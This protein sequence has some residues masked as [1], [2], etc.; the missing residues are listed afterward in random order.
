MAKSL[1]SSAKIAS[2]QRKSIT[3]KINS[4][5]ASKQL[6][7][8]WVASIRKAYSN[9]KQAQNEY[10]TKKGKWTTDKYVKS[11]KTYNNTY[12][13]HAWAIDRYS[14]KWKEYSSYDFPRW[15]AGTYQKAKLEAYWY[16][17]K[18][19]QKNQNRWAWVTWKRVPT[20]KKK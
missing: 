4:S 20:S 9:Y 17:Q 15:A 10:N 13:K 19:K 6:Y 8:R 18:D 5:S 14:G 2:E 1:K 3:N 7:D 11:V 12:N 16:A